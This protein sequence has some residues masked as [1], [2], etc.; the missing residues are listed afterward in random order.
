MAESAL[1]PRSR[2]RPPSPRVLERALLIPGSRQASAFFSPIE[3]RPEP[4]QE[5]LLEQIAVSRLAGHH[6]TLLASATGT[7]AR[8]EP[9]GFYL[10]TEQERWIAPRTRARATT[11]RTLSSPGGGLSVLHPAPPDLCRAVFDRLQAPPLPSPIVGPAQPL[12]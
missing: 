9:A 11:R 10:D 12:P 5:R 4:F 2:S 7:A 6:R 8:R 3:V 1:A